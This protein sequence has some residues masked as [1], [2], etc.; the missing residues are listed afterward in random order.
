[1]D[2]AALS[3]AASNKGRSR[4]GEGDRDGM[5]EELAEAGVL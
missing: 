2:A 1:M 4:V 3:D 5:R